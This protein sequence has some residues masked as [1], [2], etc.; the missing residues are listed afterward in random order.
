[1][2]KLAHSTSPVLNPDTNPVLRYLLKK[3][4]YAQFC[5]GE[6][7]A[8]V[9]RTVAQL[10][11]LGFKGVCLGYAKEV[12]LDESAVQKLA[13][14]GDDSAAEECIKKEILPWKEGTLKT[15]AITSPGEF[16]SIK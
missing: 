9:T 16:V 3:T 4:F 14:C 5:A 15:I 2:D 13:T 10:K 7:P 11:A 1:M 12:V 8:E 6:T